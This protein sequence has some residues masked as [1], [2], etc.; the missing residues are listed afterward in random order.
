MPNKKVKVKTLT[1]DGVNIET[2]QHFN[3]LDLILY[4]HLNWHKRNEKIA[5]KC[6]RTIGIL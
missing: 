4:I 5:N 1:N 2:V 6:S 3:F